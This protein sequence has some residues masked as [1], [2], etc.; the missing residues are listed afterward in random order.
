[1]SVAPGALAG[2]RVVE[3][4]AFVAAPSG[5][6]ALA[7]LG[8]DVIRIDPPAGGLDYHRWPLAPGGAS[9]FWAGLNKGKRSVAID[10]SKPEGRELAQALVTAPGRDAGI[11]L[12][13]FPPRGWLD[14]DALKARRNDLIQLTIQGD[15]HGGSAVDYTVNPRVGIPHIT[16]P[17]EM[18]EPVNHVLPAWDLITGQTAAL[19]LLAAERHRSRTGEGQHVRLALEDVALATLGNLGML[20]E[21][22]LGADRGRLGNDL[23]G[24]FGRDFT[25]A[26]RERVMVVALTLKQWKALCAAT[27]IGEQCRVLGA[28]LGIDLDEEGARFR[29]RDEIGALVGPW[30]GARPFAEVAKT[31]D[32]HAVCWGRY[33]TIRQ[34]VDRDPAC[35][36]ENPL[37]HRIDQP[38]VGTLLAPGNPLGFSLGRQAAQPA[39]RLGAHTGEVLSALLGLSTAAIGQLEQRG[40]IRT[41]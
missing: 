25:T 30:V 33:Q 34:L 20:A 8:A 3:V 11:L 22:Q 14:Y 9:L 27:A 23:F 12:T 29:A 28:R 41:A 26:D 32:A 4:S 10:I 16:G 13:N 5:G 21:A 15:R 31:F 39:P 1:M 38:G 7:Q 36:E 35:S 24:A 18:T 2:L 17:S 40:L 37:F 6:M 19:G